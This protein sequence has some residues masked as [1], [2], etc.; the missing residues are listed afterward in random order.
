M[1]NMR[2]SD[3]INRFLIEHNYQKSFIIEKLDITYPTYKVRMADDKWSRLQIKEL[4]SLGVITEE[5]IE[6]NGR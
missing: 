4:I 3:H 6:S 5:L 2:I 1:Q